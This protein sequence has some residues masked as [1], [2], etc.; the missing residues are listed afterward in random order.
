MLNFETTTN[1]SEELLKKLSEEKLTRVLMK[2][3]F[4][5]EELAVHFAPVDTSELVQKI[6]LFPQILAKVYILSSKAKQSEAM[7]YGTRPFY[8]PIEPLKKWAGRKLGDESIGYAI[9]KKI[10]KVGIT[11]QPFMRPSLFQVKTFWLP[12]FAAEEADK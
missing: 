1:I 6:T 4:K 10:A 11:A 12:K 3:M 2:S 5:M 7:E 9:Q 8:A